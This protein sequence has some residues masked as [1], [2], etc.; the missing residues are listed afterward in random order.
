ASRAWRATAGQC[1]GG[2][3]AIQTTSNGG[4]TWAKGASPARAIVR[5]QPLAGR[6]GFADAAGADCVLKEFT[7]NDEG[8]SWQ[9]PQPVDGGWA[10]QLGDSKL[11]V[12]PKRLNSRACGEQEVLDLARVSSTQAQVLC[13]DGGVK[14]TNDGGASWSQAGQVPDGLSLATRVKSGSTLTYAARVSATCPGIE[15]VQMMAPGSDPKRVSC[16]SAPG[17]AAAGGVSLSTP[18]GAGWLAVGDETWVAGADLR[19]WK[20]V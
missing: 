15:I 17:R 6:I 5:V 7:T 2:G 8:R 10:R 14:R 1:R 11:V 12:T 3:G 13:L 20:K 19:Q 9:G 16:V 18:S 4:A